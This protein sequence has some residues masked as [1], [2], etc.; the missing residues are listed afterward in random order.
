MALSFYEAKQRLLSGE[1][2]TWIKFGEHKAGTVHLATAG[3]RR[4]FNFLLTC[5]Q[6]KVAEA[7]ESLF[8]DLIA[9]WELGSVD[10]H[11]VLITDAASETNAVKLSSVLQ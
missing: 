7:H 8:N 3:A 11:R 10:V 1:S 9:A 5:E 4:L 2:L 6:S